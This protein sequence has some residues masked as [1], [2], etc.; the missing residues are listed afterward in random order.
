LKLHKED[1]I[2]NFVQTRVAQDKKELDSGVIKEI[3]NNCE[4]GQ[5]NASK[6]KAVTKEQEQESM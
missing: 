4:K 1:Y 2:P 6:A 5:C 3:E